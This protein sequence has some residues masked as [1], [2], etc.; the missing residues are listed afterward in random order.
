[1]YMPCKNCSFR[2][3]VRKNANYQPQQAV[4]LD[5]NA[6]T[7]PDVRVLGI[8]E[9]ACRNIWGNPSSLHGVG[10]T[11]FDLLEKYRST[12]GDSLSL[13]SP[14]RSFFT[15]SSFNAFCTCINF[16]IRELKISKIITTEIEHQSVYGAIAAIDSAENEIIYLSVD[17]NGCISLDELEKHT[18]EQSSIFLYSPVNHETGSLQDFKSIFQVTEKNRSYVIMDAV[19][20]VCRIDVRKLH[21]YSHSFVIS[22]HK[23][24]GLKGIVM[25]CFSSQIPLDEELE[26]FPGTY[27]V[28]GIAAFAETL[29]IYGN[30]IRDDLE[31]Y[32]ILTDDFYRILDNSGI[33]Y[34]RESPENA[35]AG[36]INISITGKKI[37]MEELF[38]R[39]DREKICLSRFSACSGKLNGPSLILQ[40]MGVRGMRTE[41]SLRI[42]LGRKSKRNDFFVFTKVLKNFLMNR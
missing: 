19:Q 12:I 24:Y 30:S 21:H 20:A 4:Y 36:I 27:D 7:P 11:S 33:Q 6:T 34:E 16:Y 8:Y 5:Y 18:K 41:Q 2:K 15:G 25:L 39:F 9:N 38:L 14:D 35:V 32:R 22:S 10:Q 1:M 40:S 31:Q 28:P 13:D 26:L 42:S 3:K 23:L 17:S 37:E 29:S